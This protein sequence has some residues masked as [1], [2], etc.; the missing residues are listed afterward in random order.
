MKAAVIPAAGQPPV[1]GEF[2]E[3]SA[4]E[5]AERLAVSAAALSPLSKSRASGAHYSSDSIFPSVAGVDGVGRAP[6]GRRVYFAVPLAPYGAFAQFALVP[7]DHCIPVP[8]ALSDVDAAALAN[9]GMSAWAAFAERAHI[10]PGETVLINGATGS[11]GTLS[12]QIAKLLGAGRVIATGRNA[13]SLKQTIALGAHAAIPFTIDAQHPSGAKEF[14]ENL[15]AEFS[16]GVDVVLDYLWG[17]SALAILTAAKYSPEAY[18][19]RYVQIGTA[20]HQETIGLPGAVLRSSAIQ[21]MGS[22]LRSVS[23]PRLLAAI[24]YVFQAA[25]AGQLQFASRAV[26]LSA[27]ADAWNAPGSP[28]IVFTI[29]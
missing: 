16:R 4:N 20:S 2:P 26:P 29:P 11:A 19:V 13:D 14:E 21:L 12:I 8:D 24:G 3:P 9:P 15:R 7:R 10:Q 18:P 1:Y 27:V 25:A 28:R 23:L 6:D 17:D 22:G 5:G